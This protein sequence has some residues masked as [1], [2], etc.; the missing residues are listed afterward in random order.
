MEHVTHVTNLAIRGKWP[1]DSDASDFEIRPHTARSSHMVSLSNFRRPQSVV[2]VDCSE[3]V[4]ESSISGHSTPK[5]RAYGHPQTYAADTPLVYY[6][7]FMPR[8]KPMISSTGS[9]V[10]SSQP[11]QFA[12]AQTGEFN[13]PIISR[14]IQEQ[15]AS[16][17]GRSPVNPVYCHNYNQYGS[18]NPIQTETEPPTAQLHPNPTRMLDNPNMGRPAQIMVQNP[19]AHGDINVRPISRNL[20]A[21][22]T[23]SRTDP[24]GVPGRG[25]LPLRKNRL[26]V[27]PACRKRRLKGG[28]PVGIRGGG[29]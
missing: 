6:P 10:N 15:I 5:T 16:L 25:F 22:L 8:P 3:K 23:T 4:N 9:F 7:G 18:A 26:S 1:K 29:S 28:R 2:D 14:E 21:I 17:I 24:V 19:S 12:N 27:F 11:M 20:G 13:S